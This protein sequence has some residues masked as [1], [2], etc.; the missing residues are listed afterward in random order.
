MA[1]ILR[2]GS[3]TDD[4]TLHHRPGGGID[5]RSS[6]QQDPEGARILPLVGPSRMFAQV[7]SRRRLFI[8]RQHRGRERGDGGDEQQRPAKREGHR[9]PAPAARDLLR[10][11]VERGQEGDARHGAESH[12]HAVGTHGQERQGRQKRDPPDRRPQW[13]QGREQGGGGADAEL[14]GM[15]LRENRRIQTERQVS[16]D[17]QPEGEQDEPA[18]AA[19]EQQVERAEVRR[20]EDDLCLATA[21][22]PEI[23]LA[24]QIGQHLR[25]EPERREHQ[26]RARQRI[27]QQTASRHQQ[28]GQQADQDQLGDED[29][30]HDAELHPDERGG[31]ERGQRQSLA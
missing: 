18:A 23:R 3:V 30:P 2:P 21:V 11:H 19:V 20:R 4:R 28:E 9:R 12:R 27:G 6:A 24:D 10:E 26:E 25:R 5:L 16:A 29:P 31:D 1:R 8:Q 7:P 17:R 15:S 14:P 13:D 22:V